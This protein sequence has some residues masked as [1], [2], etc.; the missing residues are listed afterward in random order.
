M[1]IP[2]FSSGG[3]MPARRK[4]GD[5]GQAG[6]RVRQA[7]IDYTLGGTLLILQFLRIP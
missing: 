6:A 3:V 4:P 2:M 7:T 1:T 5:K